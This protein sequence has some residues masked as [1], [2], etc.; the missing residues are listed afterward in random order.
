[1]RADRYIEHL[2]ITCGR[3]AE[4]IQELRA[5]VRSLTAALLTQRGDTAAAVQVRPRPP[6]DEEAPPVPRAL[7][8]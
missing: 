6:R 3:Q 8:L 1:V 7:G 2:E 5:E 4:L